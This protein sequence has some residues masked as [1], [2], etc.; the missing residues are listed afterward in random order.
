MKKAT[1]KIVLICLFILSG[2]AVIALQWEA[3]QPFRGE[4]RL[5][6]YLGAFF[7]FTASVLFY[8]C[9]WFSSRLGRDTPHLHLKRNK[10]YLFLAILFFIGCGEEISWGQRIFGWQSPAFIQEM[11]V[12][13]ET[14]F[15]NISIFNDPKYGR[16]A[17]LENERRPVLSFFL[18]IDTWFVSFWISFCLILPLV[19]RFS[20]QSRWKFSQWGLPVPPLWIGWLLFFNL[21]LYLI[22]H[23]FY[24]LNRMVLDFIELRESYAAFL[25]AVLAYHELMKLLLLFKE[26]KM[27]RKMKSK[28]HE[29]IN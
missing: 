27:L 19:N 5:I 12:Q 8:A 29:P 21:A 28:E 6:E 18:D 25:F 14:N 1:I 9:Y 24:L 2:Y 3:T 10:F 22:T 26:E 13:G 20:L 4:D 17:P 11:N 7:F 23:L 16:G 15:H